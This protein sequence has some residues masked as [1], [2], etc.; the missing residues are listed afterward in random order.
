MAGLTIELPPQQKQTEFNL[1]RW[2]ELCAD[3]ELDKYPGRVETD[4]YGRVIMLPPASPFHGGFQ[5][6]IAHVLQNLMPH[7]KVI[8]ECPVSTADGVRAADVAWA[9]PA[10][11]KKLGNASCFPTAPEICVEVISPR[12]TKAEIAEKTALYFDAGAKEV[13]HRTAAGAMKFM[14]AGAAEST[15]T[16]RLCPKF[17]KQI[18]RM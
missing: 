17:P 13:W 4:R 9:S 18:K 2:A 8:I 3:A 10:R 6:K 12:T 1:R 16:S 11:I 5:A 7:G 14:K 15:R